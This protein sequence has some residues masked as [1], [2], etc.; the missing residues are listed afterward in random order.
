MSYF[1]SFLVF[2]EHIFECENV[3]ATKSNLEIQ[4][5]SHQNPNIKFFLEI[6]KT[7]QKFIGK[8]KSFLIAKAILREKNAEGYHNIIL[9]IILQSRSN[10]ISMELAEKQTYRPTE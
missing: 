5:N 1:S 10:K 7:I 6:E 4:C 3:Y 2:L 8:H 9:Q